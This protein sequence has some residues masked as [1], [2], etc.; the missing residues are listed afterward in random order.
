MSD[1]QRWMSI[2]GQERSVPLDVKLL[3]RPLVPEAVSPIDNCYTYLESLIPLGTEQALR[4]NELLGKVLLLGVV[5]ATEHY[6]RA[7]LSRLLSVCPV[8]RKHASSQAIP[9]GALDYYPS[10]D[11]GL[12]LLE[13]ISFSTVGEVRKQTQ[14]LTGIDLKSAASLDAALADYEKLC[15]MRHAAVHAQGDFGHQNL[16][17]MGLP[18][19]GERLVLK[20]E[21]EGFQLAV[22]VCQNVVRAYNRTLYRKTI[23]RWFAEKLLIAKWQDDRFKFSALFLLFYSNHDSEGSRKAYDSYRNLLPT[24]RKSILKAPR[25]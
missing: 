8:A 10:A 5:S 17:E 15:P 24:L 21:L 12:G 11:L 25:S 16:R 23:E 9:F 4:D 3:C 2:C 1:G 19:K 18:L 13:N 14:R 22:A 7:V 6:F 20:V